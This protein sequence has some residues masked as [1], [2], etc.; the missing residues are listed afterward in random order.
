MQMTRAVDLKFF[1]EKWLKIF[2]FGA[3]AT[4]LA[5]VF[6]TLFGIFNMD[7]EPSRVWSRAE[8]LG[9]LFVCALPVG[10]MAAGA[11]TAWWRRSVLVAIIGVALVTYGPEVLS[12]LML[13]AIGSVAI[14]RL[15]YRVDL[16][17]VESVL[18]AFTLGFG[19]LG[20]LIGFTVPATIHFDFVYGAIFLGA[21]AMAH[22]PIFRAGQSLGASLLVR[23]PAQSRKCLISRLF[24]SLCVAIALLLML[25]ASARES[26]FDALTTHLYFIDQLKINGVFNY[27]IGM[28]PFVYMP[29]TA[30]WSLAPTHILGG[31][32]ALRA[33]NASLLL[34]VAGLVVCRTAPTMG[35][36]PSALLAACFLSAPLV[37]WISSQLFE[38]NA[39]TLFIVASAVLFL[40]GEKTDR[41]FYFDA[42]ALACLGLAVSSKPQA[43]FFGGLGAAIVL[44]RLMING[45]TWASIKGVILGSGLFAALAI[46]P[47]LR[48]LINTGNPFHP[49]RAGSNHDARWDHDLTLMTPYEMIFQTSQYM[50]AWP[51]GF[52]VQFILLL[53]SGFLVLL[54]GRWQ[55]LSS[56]GLVALVFCTALATQSVYARYQIY[57][58]PLL[59]ISVAA[60]YPAL[61]P[62]GRAVI[63]AFLL[64]S[65][66]V[67]L[68]FW[69]RT[70]A[71]DFALAQVLDPSLSPQ[72]PGER[73]VFDVLNARYGPDTSVY[74]AGQM[75]FAGGLEG[76]AHGFSQQA[77]EMT[78]AQT[79]T[80][81]AKAMQRSGVTHVLLAG[82]PLNPL[83]EELCQ[84]ACV[85]LHP[86]VGGMD[87][88]RVDQERLEMVANDARAALGLGALQPA[89]GSDGQIVRGFIMMD[90][91]DRES[92]GWWSL[93]DSSTLRLRDRF[94]SATALRI[95]HTV[96][97]P[98]GS[99]ALL[100]EV[101]LDGVEIARL[102]FGNGVTGSFE[103]QDIILPAPISADQPK[104]LRFSYSS[105]LSPDAYLANGDQRQIAIGISD[106]EPLS[107]AD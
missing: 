77:S 76:Q 19:T 86:I 4:V 100:V 36:G 91:W 12:T 3:S 61:M 22:R 39:T 15:I 27:D 55:S 45:V 103:I 25:Y 29:K 87:V 84:I 66:P 56:L 80:S 59:M 99:G 90:G 75:R 43:L 2:R 83:I 13:H 95:T 46:A 69:P 50:E 97:R 101:E 82:E 40:R 71:P 23:S 96:F 51:G 60:L 72:V 37:F 64:F 28:S 93:G 42:L 58:F 17:S 89:P 16:D 98:Q 81:L 88:F 1:S 7:P 94:N 5:A 44:R 107:N 38:E 24:A 48:A 79:L 54:L 65:I 57:A 26:G 30:V 11:F 31:E 68:A 41:P 9:I 105:P 6:V 92:W 18:I 53:V 34:A 63:T 102:S 35:A 33:M 106:I 20:V 47:Y 104:I 8:L 10:I 14:G 52:A 49:F 62:W 32:F 70:N 74:M 73:R 85:L 21:I 78:S 67:N